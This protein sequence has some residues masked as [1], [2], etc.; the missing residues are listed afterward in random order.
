[1][2]QNT[3]KGSSTVASASVKLALVFA[4]GVPRARVTPLAP[5]TYQCGS[6]LAAVDIDP[7]ALA[8]VS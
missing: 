6:A 7:D 5:S 2:L 1:M 4:W 3:S 8:A